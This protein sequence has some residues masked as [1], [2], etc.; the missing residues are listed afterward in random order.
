[1]MLLVAITALLI[2]QLCV[3]LKTRVVVALHDRIEKSVLLEGINIFF[4]CKNLLRLF[5]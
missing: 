5:Y 4:I 1:M 2:R 3:L